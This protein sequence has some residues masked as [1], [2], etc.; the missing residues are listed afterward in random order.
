[1][2]RARAKPQP[3]R[4]ATGPWSQ[5]LRPQRKA[6]LKLAAYC[7]RSRC[8]RGP[9]A[10][11]RFRSFF[12]ARE[13]LRLLQRNVAWFRRWKGANDGWL[14]ARS[15][16]GEA[17]TQPPQRAVA[18]N[19]EIVAQTSESA[20][21]PISNRQRVEILKVLGLCGVRR[22]EALRHSRL[23]SLRYDFRNGLGLRASPDANAIEGNRLV[24][25]HDT[26]QL[27]TKTHGLEGRHNLP[28]AG[29]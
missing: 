1:M 8:G 18:A 7:E 22:L 25:G 14:W 26:L 12:A 29:S 17:R 6:C 5:R 13:Q 28:R 10:R 20:V 4:T 15:R 23:G 9:P 24:R 27:G 19:G 21:S 11:R 3:R 16:R 2:N